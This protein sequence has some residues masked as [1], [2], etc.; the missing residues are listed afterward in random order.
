MTGADRLT[1]A[2]PGSARTNKLNVAWPVI[3]RRR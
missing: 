2:P 3:E 1:P